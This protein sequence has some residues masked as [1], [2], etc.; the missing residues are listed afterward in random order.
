MPGSGYLINIGD[1]AEIYKPIAREILA[2]GFNINNARCVLCT[3]AVLNATENKVGF[4]EYDKYNFGP[5][6]CPACEYNRQHKISLDVP[7]LENYSSVLKYKSYTLTFS[8]VEQGIFHV[9]GLQPTD[10]LDPYNHMI[11]YQGG[12][13]YEVPEE[14]TSQYL[15]DICRVYGAQAKAE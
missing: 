6:D 14:L 9:D 2:P 12:V 3:V 1:I 4:V 15:S 11:I 8:G 7:N 5:H 13:W 10:D